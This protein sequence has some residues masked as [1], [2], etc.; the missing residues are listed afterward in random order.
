MSKRRLLETPVFGEVMSKSKFIL[1]MKFLHFAN[2]E[3]DSGEA[4][5]ARQKLS[6]IWPVLSLLKDR[7]KTGYMP[8]EQISI[9]ESLMLLQGT[10]LLEAIPSAEAVA[11]WC[12]ALCVVRVYNRLRIR[13]HHETNGTT[14]EPR[15]LS[16]CR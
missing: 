15:L 14:A 3:D 5:Q 10:S 9:D 7:F 8:E 12:E 13:H 4:G 1:L 6:K 2:Y 11:L 16:N